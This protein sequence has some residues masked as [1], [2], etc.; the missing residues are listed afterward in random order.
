MGKA[1]CFQGRQDARCRARRGFEEGEVMKQRGGD[2][3]RRALGGSGRYCR[4][5]RAKKRQSK[6][7]PMPAIGY[8]WETRR[9]RLLG[10]MRCD[11]TTKVRRHGRKGMDGGMG[12]EDELLGGGEDE[13]CAQ[14]LGW[15]VGRNGML[16][17]ELREGFPASA[18]ADWLTG[19]VG[20]DTDT[21]RAGQGRASSPAQLI[22][23]RC[24]RDLVKLLTDR[25][26]LRILHRNGGRLHHDCTT[27]SNLLCESAQ[28]LDSRQQPRP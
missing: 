22:D 8:R 18:S 12:D 27:A 7:K 1:A 2:S 3:A 23:C 10:E 25:M 15:R 17:F 26:K 19:P 11:E 14:D 24:Q 5:T 20:Q 21:G 28:C 16:L 9:R 13:R 6:R 4:W